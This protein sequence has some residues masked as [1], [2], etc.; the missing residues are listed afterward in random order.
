MKILGVAGSPRKESNTEK[1]V[2]EALRVARSVAS[3]ETELITLAGLKIMACDGCFRCTENPT[4]HPC[5]SFNDDMTPLYRKLA[6]ADGFIFASPTYF[7]TVPGHMKN[8]M[9]RFIPLFDSPDSK[10]TLKGSLKFKPAGAISLAGW[11]N[12]GIEAV[13]ATLCR[14][15]LINNMIVVGTAGASNISSNLGAAVV[16]GDKADVLSRDSL[17]LNGIQAV[18]RKVAIVAKMLKKGKSSVPLNSFL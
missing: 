13:L 16:T 14:F 5:I 11:R 7:G 9:D 12:D 17:G 15:F 10:S 1:C 18:G 2:R 8:F 4:Q 3:V 6:S